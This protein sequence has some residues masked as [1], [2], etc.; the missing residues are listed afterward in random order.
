VIEPTVLIGSD[1][2]A[3]AVIALT[4]S[5]AVNPAAIVVAGHP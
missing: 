5:Q 2:G 4:A 1:T 3:V